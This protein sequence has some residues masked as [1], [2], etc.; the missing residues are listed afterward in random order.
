[1]ADASIL[2]IDDDVEFAAEVSDY[3][4]RYAFE[5]TVVHALAP[6]IEALAR[7]Q[8]DV[9]ILDQFLSK[10]DALE[11]MPDIRRLYTG[12]LMVLTGNAD[13]S[14]RVKG[15]EIGADDFVSK[16]TPPREI[17]A[18]VRA[19]AR[20][21]RDVGPPADALP[22]GPRP[23]MDMMRRVVIG[24]AGESIE[25]T[26]A[27]FEMLRML[28]EQVGQPIERGVLSQHVLKRPYSALDRS[29]D[30]I[31]GHLRQKLEPF[32][33]GPQIILSVRNVGYCFTGFGADGAS[34]PA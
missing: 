11:A 34:S 26:G 29:V 12:P 13:P 18:R 8:P 19:L 24:P 30:N 1:M 31:I 27:E 2:L 10:S 4:S 32:G 9:V 6:A 7:S 14:D 16:T 25:L 28:V 3:L 23:G 17:L 5:V 22:S 33:R 20:R 21:G 15:L